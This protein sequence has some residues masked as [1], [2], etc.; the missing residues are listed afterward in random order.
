M[1]IL[2]HTGELV[3]VNHRSVQV[4]IGDPGQAEKPVRSEVGPY[5]VVFLP[6]KCAYEFVRVCRIVQASQVAG[7]AEREAER[8]GGKDAVG[9]QVAIGQ[10]HLPAQVGGVRRHLLGN[11]TGVL[12]AGVKYAHGD[13]F[14][15][16]SDA[17]A[18]ADRQLFGLGAGGHGK[19]PRRLAFLGVY[20]DHTGAHVA[21]L[22]ARH[23][24]NNFDRL[25]V[26]GSYVVGGHALDV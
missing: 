13:A 25:H 9:Y 17:E 8:L 24:G 19:L 16:G 6:G 1:V 21:V 22:H 12:E 23:T 18:L 14:F 3:A 2:V 5:A 10:R 26:R 20:L 15:R 11:G 4:D 7:D